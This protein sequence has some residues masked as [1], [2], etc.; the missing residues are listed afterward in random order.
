MDA[1]KNSI[2]LIGKEPGQER[3]L[4]SV[5]TNG[6]TKATSIGNMGN[7]PNS[8]SRC[9]PAEGIAHCKITTDANGTMVLTN[10]KSQ[11]V[12]YVNG[13]EIVSKKISSESNIALGKDRY[14]INLHTI[15][16]AAIKIAGRRY[17]VP[18]SPIPNNNVRSIRHL[19]RVW[20]D[21]DKG[22]YDLQ[23]R[24]K[25]AGIFRSLYLPIVVLSTLLGYAL[26]F[27]G[28]D[29]TLTAVLSF[30]FYI[31]AAIVLFYGLYKAIKDNSIE[32]RKELNDK[33]QDDYICPHCNHFLGFQAYKILKQNTNC[34]YCKGG[35]TE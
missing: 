9:K 17:D 27:A 30:L 10:L 12:T 19:E 34:P 32:E 24:Q 26:N 35:F 3:I 25:K 1:L 21:Y 20:D 23:I 15:V 5:T 31:I 6:Q 29:K 7:V 16:D 28:I 18:P 8:V 13:T 2:I 4:I 11:N 14:P 33:F 22:L